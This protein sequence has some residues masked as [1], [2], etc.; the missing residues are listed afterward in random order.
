M[1]ALAFAL[2]LALALPLRPEY[3]LQLHSFNDLR[4]V[5]QAL[6][7]IA[8]QPSGTLLKLDPQYLPP[9]LCA[10]QAR[11][12]APADP[13]GCLMLNHDTVTQAARRTLN[14]SADLLALLASPGLARYTASAASPLV[15]SLCFKG[16]GGARGCPCDA[17]AQSAA[18]LSLADD[19]LGALGALAN[20]SA[21]GLRVVLDGDANPGAAACLAQRWRPLESVFISGDDPAAAFTRA[22]ASLGYDRLLTLNENLDSFQVAAALGFGRFAAGGRPYVMWEPSDAAGMATAARRAAR[23]GAG[24][25]AS[26]GAAYCAGSTLTAQSMP[27]ACGGAPAARRAA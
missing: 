19:L 1:R 9:P 18:W 27:G 17:S 3:G 4:S 10:L 11:A 16:C 6:A 2:S 21:G 12:P 26:R 22:N 20:A 8:P 13:R 25:V 24:A 7:K 15:V 14:S 23:Q 5:P